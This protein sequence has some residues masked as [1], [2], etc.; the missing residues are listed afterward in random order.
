[1]SADEAR[2]RAYDDGL[3]LVEVSATAKPP[4]WFMISLARFSLVPKWRNKVTSLTP[5]LS[6]MARVVV[7]AYPISEKRSE[8]ALSNLERVS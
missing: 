6:A 8:A 4:N 3:D 2:E 7:P 5:A 1:M